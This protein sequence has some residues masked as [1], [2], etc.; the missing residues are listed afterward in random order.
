MLY[1]VRTTFLGNKGIRRLLIG[2]FLVFLSLFAGIFGF[3]EIEG[4]DM[5][6]AFFMTVITV[7]TVG[8]NEVR[9]LSPDGRLF[10]SFYIIFNLGIFGYVVSIITS[11]LFEGELRQIFRQYLRGQGV[12]KVKEHVI[13]VGYG[14]NGRKACTEL[15]NSHQPFVVIDNSPDRIGEMPEAYAKM[16]IEGDATHD[17]TLLAAGVKKAKA[18][19]TTLPND[20]ENVFITLTARGLSKDIFIVARASEEKSIVKLHRAGA[21]KVVMPD[22]LGGIYMAHLISK[23]YVNEFLELF[24]GMGDTQLKLEEFNYDQ[25][26]DDCRDKTI[27][28]LDVR[29]NTG[30]TVVGFKDKKEGFKFRPGPNTKISNEDIV[31]VLGK[32]E[33][34]D[35]FR[36]QFIR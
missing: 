19:I 34:I 27:S 9:P 7:S 22:T 5:G 4:F 15:E 10:T 23:P 17:E 6:E 8:Y 11:Y 16:A 35:S 28:Q 14:R 25:F 1:G 21:D 12:K 3:M 30:V 20:A 29:K 24:A 26:R 31:I 2:I 13:V 18:V 36:E 33:E 32:D